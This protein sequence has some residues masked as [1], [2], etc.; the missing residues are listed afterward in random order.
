MARSTLDDEI[1]VVFAVCSGLGL[2]EVTLTTLKAA[3]HTTFLVSPLK[4]VARVQSSEPIDPARETAIREV[5]IARHL[6]GE[7]APALAP[8]KDVAGPHVLESCVVTLWPYVDHGRVAE[9]KDAAVAATTLDSVHRT[10]RN[11]SGKLP[12]Y[13]E[14]LDHCCSVLVDDDACSRLGSRDRELLKAQYRRLRSE[15]DGA[16]SHWIS[17]HG[18]PHLGNLLFGEHGPLWLDFED[19]CL[20]PREYD[21]A[22]LPVTTW[23]QFGDAD[24]M[25][26]RNY[27]DLRSI[28]IAV[29]CWDDPDRSDGASEA[30]QYNLDRVRDFAV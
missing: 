19:A 16:A 15:V 30:A 7:S 8:L 2:G 12:A 3:H 25:L 23:S 13:T 21:I 22:C 14:A 27:A 1:A 24:Q 28:C 20:G 5:A 18:D 9:L 10:L 4:I 29:W 11:Y 26:I 6:A 17:L